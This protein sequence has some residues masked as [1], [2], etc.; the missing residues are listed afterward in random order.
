MSSERGRA[1]LAACTIYRDD[2]DYLGE[3]IEF[4]RLVGVERFVLY[5]NGSTDHHLDVLAPYL[6]EGVAIRHDWPLPFRGESGRP[7]AMV[8]AFEHCV[9]VHRDDARWI[10]FLD[11]DEFLFSPTGALLPELLP[12]YE[13]FPA[14]IVNRAEFGPSGHLTKPQGLVIESYVERWQLRPDDRAQYKSILDPARVAWCTSAH[15]FVYH[16]GVPVNEEMS[17]VTRYGR[18]PDSWARLKIHHYPLRSLEERRRKAQKWGDVGSSRPLLTGVIETRGGTVRD[19][20]LVAYA[21]AVR[22]A[23]DRRGPPAAG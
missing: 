8:L 13:R 4:H 17:A 2:A 10:A 15:K 14:V 12:E 3:W 20:T 1:Y 6:E 18:K 5:D 11:V 19:E 9:G 16:D 22:E 23:L 7:K 21:P